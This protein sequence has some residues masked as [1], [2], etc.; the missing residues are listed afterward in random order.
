MGREKGALAD[1]ST[2]GGGN[3]MW[4]VPVKGGAQRSGMKNEH[5][6]VITPHDFTPCERQRWRRSTDPVPSMRCREQVRVTNVI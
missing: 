4:E 1:W 5:R 3:E 2:V 6:L